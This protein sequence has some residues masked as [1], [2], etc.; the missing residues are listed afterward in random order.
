MSRIWTRC[1]FRKGGAEWACLTEA[2][3]FEARGETLKGQ[4]AV[5]EVI[6]NRVDNRK[7]PDSI[8]GVITQGASKRHK[9]QFSFKC[10]G[11][12][13]KILGTARL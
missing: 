3:Y 9:C 6:L 2:L 8:C 11:R 13:E 10:D 1:P 5:A 12:P 4:L 7:Y